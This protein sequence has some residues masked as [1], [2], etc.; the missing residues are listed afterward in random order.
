MT[1]DGE[2]SPSMP[3]PERLPLNLQNSV[4]AFDHIWYRRDLDL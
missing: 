4:S 2:P 1:L 3:S